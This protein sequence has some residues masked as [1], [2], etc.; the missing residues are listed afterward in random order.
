M[1]HE[2]PHD[3]DIA[4]AKTVTARAFESYRARFAEY[5]PKLEWVTDRNARIEF[6]V[7]SW[8]LNGSIGLRAG[9]IELD[10]DVPWL[11][12]PFRNTAIEVIEKEVR[13]WI[14]KAKAG[15]LTPAPQTGS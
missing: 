4:T 10:L 3:L 14:A 1:K 13:I 2:I 6:K 9:S 7:K 15:Q 8:T 5:R 11:L 12:R